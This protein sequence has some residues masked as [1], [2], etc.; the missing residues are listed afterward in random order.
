MT[1]INKKSLLGLGPNSNKIKKYKAQLTNL[2]STQFDSAIGLI[3]GDASLNTDNKGKTY[4]I[5]FKWG[6]RQT[7][8]V[9]HVLTLFDEWIISP[10]HKKVRISP[11]GNTITNWGF[12]T[13]SHPAFNVLADLF[14]VNNVKMVPSL[15]I[16]NHLTA[17]GLAYWF[18]DDGGKLDYNKNSKNK[19][20]KL[21]EKE[22][23]NDSQETEAD[24]DE[25]NNE[26]SGPSSERTNGSHESNQENLMTNSP[27]NSD[28]SDLMNS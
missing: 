24:F 7:P 12:Q 15:L 22:E 5:K 13:F 27:N 6:N 19:G 26:Y 21:D 23:T 14:L 8:Y 17:R 18:M 2:T 28:N 4:R 9:D 1:N 25:P 20:S 3:L 10:P 16:K 11:K